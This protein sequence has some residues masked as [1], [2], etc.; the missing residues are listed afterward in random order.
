MEKDKNNLDMSPQSPVPKNKL[1]NEI[2]REQVQVSADTRASKCRDLDD[3][4]EFQEEHK[5]MEKVD[6]YHDNFESAEKQSDKK[7]VSKRTATE[8]T[9]DQ[10]SNFKKTSKNLSG[11]I[12]KLEYD[13]EDEEMKEDCQIDED[14]DEDSYP[15]YDSGI[16]RF[17]NLG[18]S[19]KA[20][21]KQYWTKEEDDKLQAL[22]NK[23]GAKN[24]KRIASY[25][26]TR[27]DVQCLHRWQK[28]LNPDL[29]KGPWTVEED[30]KVIEMVKKHGAKNWSA[31]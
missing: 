5:N 31:I 16:T 15:K 3:S 1:G 2:G 12:K 17:L 25:F 9:P 14:S 22:V 27:T 29:V 7:K 13:D 30:Q 11:V 8:M 28:V 6:P 23:Y 19:K 18:P 26:D 24:W 20:F 21:H 4:G 10:T